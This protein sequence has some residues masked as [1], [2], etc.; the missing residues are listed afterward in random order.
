MN[1][2]GIKR[3]CMIV[4]HPYPLAE[5]RVER[6]AQAL[7][8]HG[9]EVDVICL[10]HSPGE[11][12]FEVVEDVNVHRLP[13]R[14]DKQRGILRQL[15]EYMSFLLLA[16]VKVA[17]LYQKRRYG[18]VEVHNLPDFLVFAAIWPK[19]MGARVILNIHDV[20]PEF[21][22]ARFKSNRTSWIVRLVR[23][24]ER[25]SCRFADSVIITTHRWRNAL[26]ERGVPARKIFVVMNLADERIF[27]QPATPRRHR[28]GEAF[29]VVYHGTITPRYG[30]DLAI[31]AS[32]RLRERIP[33]YRLFLVG[34][35]EYRE[36]AMKLVRELELQSSVTF[37][38]T[39]PLAE[40]PSLIEQMDAGV[41]SYKFDGFTDGCLPTKLLEYTAMGI[42]SVVAPTPVI[43]DYFDESLVEFC[44]PEDPHDLAEHIYLLYS[45]PG[46]YNELA[47]NTARFNERYNWAS[48]SAEYVRL[49]DRMNDSHHAFPRPSPPLTTRSR[50]KRE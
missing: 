48:M 46:R 33:G 29:H 44:A 1:K 8:R 5:P 40:L 28:G 10:L 42:P 49:V 16:L 41:T 24:E 3:H 14:R 19:L 47:S 50:T 32:A 37:L 4:H 13:V 31:H 2:S 35:G 36:E 25:I 7:I 17:R 34:R 30:V 39:K 38:D 11:S 43:T 26:V 20:M 6:E 45:N 18:V 21:Y 23:L 27:K 9:Y 15:L 22:A 12:A